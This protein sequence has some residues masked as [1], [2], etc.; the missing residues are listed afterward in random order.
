MKTRHRR[1]PVATAV[2][3]ALALAAGQ[4]HG[5]A[6]GLAEQAGSGQGNAFAGGAAAAEDAS[7]VWFNP[8]GM[9]RLARPEVAASVHLITPS[10]KFRNDG[11]LAA[12]G[13]P[14]GHDGGDAGTLNIVPN[15]ALTMPL[16]KEWSIGLGLNVPFGLVTHYGEGWIG[17]Y[18]GVKSEVETINV[19]PAVSYKFDRFSIGVG[20]NYQRI[21]ATFTS[22][23]NYSGALAQVASGFAAAGVPGFTAATVAAI[24][25][26][27]PGLDANATIDGDDSAWGWNV[28]VLFDLDRNSR[29]GV[30]YRS[31]IKYDITGNARFDIPTLPA[32]PPALAP[33]VTGVAN[34]LVTPSAANAN[35][36]QLAATGVRS[37]IEVPD[38][39]NASYFRTLNDRWDIM[40]DVQWTRWSTIKDLTFTR[41][42][43]TVLQSTPFNWDDSW[44]YS[45]GA[46]YRYNDKLMLRGGVAFD[47]TPISDEFRTVRLPDSDRWWLSVGAQYKFAPNMKLDA[48]FTYIIADKVDINKTGDPPSCTST[49]AC[50]GGFGLV[51]GH[52]DASVTILS[53]QFT[54]TF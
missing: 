28:G 32:L 15:L 52:Y 3:A 33:A 20:A 9:S 5:S 36:P 50:V 44:R 26:A 24:A 6:F 40:A 8:A 23:V 54:Y 16:T 35:N 29:I 34:F 14:L 11:S 7:T 47:E 4:A 22:A 25:G 1:T 41:A 43:G 51:K 2:A 46:N 49:P 42:N 12:A 27:T 17:R 30:A 13:Q 37:T 21:D 10:I 38:K 31:K 53:A 18:Q 48:G 45:V 19:S 39:V